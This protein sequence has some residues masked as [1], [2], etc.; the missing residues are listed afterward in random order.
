MTSLNQPAYIEWLALR[1]T[2]WYG[3]VEYRAYEHKIRN[4]DTT[5]L[6]DEVK[7]LA[8][9][10]DALELE[11]CRKLEFVLLTFRRQTGKGGAGKIVEREF[12]ASISV[13]DPDAALD[14]CL[15]TPVRR[16]PQPA[17]L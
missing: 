17:C 13:D 12:L 7:L 5:T 15:T 16:K 14:A 2:V 4:P 9:L 3:D 11:R 10:G 6:A 8:R 1:M